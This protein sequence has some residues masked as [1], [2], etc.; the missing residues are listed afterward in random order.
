M[1]DMWR[2]KRRVRERKTEERYGLWG[3]EREMGRKLCGRE[4]KENC[5]RKGYREEE[6]ESRRRRR[7]EE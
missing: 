1:R 4:G 5:E 7:G 3:E 6:R 2:G